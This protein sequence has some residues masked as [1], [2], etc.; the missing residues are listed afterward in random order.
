MQAFGPGRPTPRDAV[1]RR[2]LA[3]ADVCA[4]AGGLG[5][6]AL[7][8]QQRLGLASIATLPLIVLIMKLSGRYDHDEVVLR[9]STLDEAPALTALAAAYALAWSLV[10]ITLDIHSSR[11]AVIVLWGATAAFLIA[12]RATARALA[13]RWAPPERIL[14]IGGTLA[15]TGIARRLAAS[16]DA[17]VEIVGYLPIEGEGY[18]AGEGGPADPRIKNLSTAD[19]GAA[20]EKLDAHRVMVILS[21]TDPDKVLEAVVRANTVGVKV[22]MVPRIFEVVGS[23]VEFDE[24]GGVTVLGVRRPGLSRSSIV[25]KRGMDIVGS[26]IGLIGL[27]PVGLL[28]AL[29]IK[30]DSKGPVFFRQPRI[31]RNGRMFQMVKFRSMI[32]EAEAQRDELETLNESDG[33][34]KISQDPRV[35]RV[36]RWLRRSSLD[37]LPQLINVLRGEMSLVGPRPLVP[38]ED[39]RVEGRHRSRLQLSPGMTGP[40]QV[41]GP[42]RP[43]LSEMVKLDYLYGANWSLWSDIKCLLRTIGHVTNRRGV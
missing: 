28:V 20:V 8:S 17:R 37:E 42:D 38:E 35:T 1:F 21:G 15:R 14:I 7:I 11:G 27:A 33:I 22:S 41:L 32:L 16:F 13:Q 34:F 3:L 5:A 19:L 6:A 24:V 29:A 40:W 9:K 10:T 31:G 18:A 36:G 43:P 39:R 12:L 2:S 30:L 25:T 26:A 23:S 4:A